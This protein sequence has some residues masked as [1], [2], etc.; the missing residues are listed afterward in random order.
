MLKK[1]LYLSLGSM[2]LFAMHTAELNINDVDLEVGVKFDIGQFNDNIRPDT[3]FVGITYLN[4]SEDNSRNENGIEVAKLGEYLNVNFLMKQKINNI[5]L[6]VGLGVKAV[7]ASIDDPDLSLY[8]ALPLGVE[9]EYM[10][11]IKNVIPISFEAQIYYAP[12]SLS[13]S[14]AKSYLE[15]RVEANFEVIERGTLYVGLRNIDTNYDSSNYQ[16]NRAGYF[17]FKF[18]F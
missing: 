5:D 9:V 16:Y 18:A 11:P 7:F 15:Y 13:F 3:T 1:I 14:D 8:S 10:L 17:G 2:S 12:E 4:A 6:K